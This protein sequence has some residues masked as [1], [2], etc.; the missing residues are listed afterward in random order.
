MRCNATKMTTMTT[1]IWRDWIRRYIWHMSKKNWKCSG[2]RCRFEISIDRVRRWIRSSVVFVHK[3]TNGLFARCHGA[4]NFLPYNC[5]VCGLCALSYCV[6]YTIHRRRRRRLSVRLWMWKSRVFFTI[7]HFQFHDADAIYI[8][9]DA[10]N[11]VDFKHLN[12]VQWTFT[13]RRMH[14]CIH[15]ISASHSLSS[16]SRCAADGW[17]N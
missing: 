13:R 1:T 6:Y 3:R 10:P 7:D 17:A 5:Y 9:I 12:A 4:H 16:F 8:A 11:R 2:N 15:A 14:A